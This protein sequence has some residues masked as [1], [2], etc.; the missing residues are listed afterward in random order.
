MLGGNTLLIA[1]SPCPLPQATTIVTETS[2]YEDQ[3]QQ[4]MID[5]VEQFCMWAGLGG[6]EGEGGTCWMLGSTRGGW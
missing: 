3:E 6:G 1:Y 5:S 4:L 2:R